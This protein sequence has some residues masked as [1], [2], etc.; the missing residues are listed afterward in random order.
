MFNTILIDSAGL[1]RVPPGFWGGP[2]YAH[3]NMCTGFT[4]GGWGGK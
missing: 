2:S 3:V 1:S 4:Y